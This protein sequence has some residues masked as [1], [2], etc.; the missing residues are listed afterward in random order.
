MFTVFLLG[1]IS[2]L[3]VCIGHRNLAIA[4]ALTTTLLLAGLLFHHMTSK[5]PISL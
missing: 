1:L 2:A 3:L 4:T 5:L